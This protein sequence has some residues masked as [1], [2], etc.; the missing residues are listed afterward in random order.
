MTEV[1]ERAPVL[2]LKVRELET[3]C[4]RL[5]V[6]VVTHVKYIVALVLESAVM[7]VF[8]AFAAVP[9]MLVIPVN[10]IAELDLLIAM[11]V[12]PR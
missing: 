12:V 6:V 3:F 7:A 5:P 8:V 11:P 9:S 4:G 1:A 10:A 2:G